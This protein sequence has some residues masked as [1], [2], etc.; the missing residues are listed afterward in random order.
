MRFGTNPTF[1]LE[2]VSVS[3]AI[4][5]T[6]EPDQAALMENRPDPVRLLEFTLSSFPLSDHSVVYLYLLAD[7]FHARLIVVAP[8]FSASI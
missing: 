8:Q 1:C 2:A 7:F 4:I 5:G 6:W 3:H